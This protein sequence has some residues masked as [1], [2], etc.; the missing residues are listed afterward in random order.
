MYS[1]EARVSSAGP[2]GCFKGPQSRM[3]EIRALKGSFNREY[4]NMDED[5]T[6]VIMITESK[7]KMGKKNL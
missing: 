2:H 3:S 4:T 5:E 1:E 7:I 6:K